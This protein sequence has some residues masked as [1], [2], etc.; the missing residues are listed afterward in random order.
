MKSSRLLIVM[1]IAAAFL[2]AGVNAFADKA[3]KPAAPAAKAAFKWIPTKPGIKAA[4]VPIG[5]GVICPFEFTGIDA[6]A[7]KKV[8]FS[9]KDENIAKM[10]I[11]ID[12]EE[13]EVKDGKAAASAMISVSKSTKQGNYDLTIVA[14][15]AATGA[16]IGEG[17]IPFQVISKSAVGC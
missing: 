3:A 15:D 4:Q 17:V 11:A 9:I 8:K 6:K 16:V 1:I 10:G 7:S 12:N 5:K 14:K 13:V 2:A